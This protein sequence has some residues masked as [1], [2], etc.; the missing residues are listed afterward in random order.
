MQCVRVG[1]RGER[2][3]SES[4]GGGGEVHPAMKTDC[5]CL[6]VCPSRSQGRPGLCV[7]F[8][9]TSP[10]FS[11][12][13]VVLITLKTQKLERFVLF[14]LF[15]TS[16]DLLHDASPFERRILTTKTSALKRQVFRT[17][18][19]R[20]VGLGSANG[21]DRPSSW[22]GATE[23]QGWQSESG[24]KGLRRCHSR[25]FRFAFHS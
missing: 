14:S 19:K 8:L 11:I 9:L 23:F 2:G 16:A 7:R 13:I 21:S 24:E 18:R 4:G 10:F 3:A 5:R 17:Q 15:A 20:N 12:T 22:C 1:P 25:N 6:R